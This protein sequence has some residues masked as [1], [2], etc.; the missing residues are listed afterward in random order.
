MDPAERDFLDEIRLR[1]DD[2][3]ARLVYADWLIERGDWRGEWISIQC[4][5][6]GREKVRQHELLHEHA[7]PELA[8]LL[9]D[10][11]IANV[12]DDEVMRWYDRGFLQGLTVREEP[13]PA[14]FRMAPVIHRLDFQIATG[15]RTDVWR[16]AVRGVKGHVGHAAVKIPSEPMSLSESDPSAQLHH[17]AAVFEAVGPHPNL[18]DYLGRSVFRGVLGLVVQWSP[19]MTLRDYNAQRQGVPAI[20]VAAGVGVQICRAL[21]HLHR[22]DAVHREVRPDHILVDPQGVAKIF[23]LG[24][25]R[26]PGRPDPAAMYTDP[27]SPGPL[28][29]D[30][31][32]WSYMAPEAVRGDALDARADLFSLGAVLYELA[33][34]AHAFT[35]DFPIGI[36]RNLIRGEFP[37]PR[38]VVAD[39][40]IDLENV[41]L[42]ALTVEPDARYQ[43]ATQMRE[44][45]EAV[46]RDHGWEISSEALR[47]AFWGNTA[48]EGESVERDFWE[49]R[50]QSNRIGFHRDEVNE[51]LADHGSRLLTGKMH[52][53]LVPLCGK[54]KDM[55]WLARE[56]HHV[57]GV[58]FV[59]KALYE[60]FS[61]EE[62]TFQDETVRGHRVLTG[63]GVRL[64]CAD[65]FDVDHELVG[66][67]DRVYDR[68]ALIALPPDRRR[69]YAAKIKE[70]LGADGRML[71]IT[72]AYDQSALDG[73][74][75]SVPESEVRAL[76]EPEL[77][78]ESLHEEIAASVPVR[79]SEQ[80]V[81]VREQVWLLT[82]PE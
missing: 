59:E 11:L 48:P 36:L 26:L 37:A 73:P 65:F 71:L 28:P 52:R 72:I 56:G 7:R 61:D 14:H 50:W 24:W 20:E 45:L 1:P 69:R 8:S 70:L 19:G 23:D 76:F 10:E 6:T 30:G 39:F 33:T 49:S 4:N 2:V 42:R 51:H 5:P 9:G 3:A 62:L 38:N 68:A 13:S 79:F 47:D 27:I 43:T 58:E 54:S 80:D 22:I 74:P 29:A 35:G 44:A 82:R 34:G 78:V 75:F 18:L 53:V 40:P 21:E 41:L 15:R 66:D 25:A 57:T 55:L 16:V 63:H 77:T 64:V 81:E 31:W 46:A 17:E 32:R 12:P 60:F 67:I